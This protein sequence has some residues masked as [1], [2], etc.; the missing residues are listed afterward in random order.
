MLGECV[1][2]LVLSSCC[3]YLKWWTSV[4]AG[5]QLRVLFSKQTKVYPPG[6]RA[7]QPLRRGILSSSWHP[8]FISFSILPAP[9]LC[10]LSWPGG[11]SVSSEVLTPVPG[12]SFVPFSWAFPFLCL[13]SSVQFSH[14]VVSNS[15]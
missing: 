6:R 7:C 15:L 2:S 9:V 1:T 13:F 11:L 8:L 5:F 10:K 14:S 3:K 4:T 12:F